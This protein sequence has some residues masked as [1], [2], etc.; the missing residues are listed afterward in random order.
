MRNIRSR[1][2]LNL[3]PKDDVFLIVHE[4][5]LAAIFQLGVEFP[6]RRAKAVGNNVVNEVLYVCGDLNWLPSFAVERETG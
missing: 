1:I 6:S 3:I 5:E 4:Q 2:G